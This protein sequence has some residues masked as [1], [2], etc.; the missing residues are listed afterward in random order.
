MEI[1]SYFDNVCF[2]INVSLYNT[3]GF[4]ETFILRHDIFP[5]Y[6]S[7]ILKAYCE[8]KGPHDTDAT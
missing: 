1:R 8:F 5:L 2:I 4:Q 7:N 3:V 6:E